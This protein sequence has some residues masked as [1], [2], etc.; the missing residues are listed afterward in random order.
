LDAAVVD[1]EMLFFSFDLVVGDGCERR[2]SSEAPRKVSE[3]GFFSLG[4]VRH[5]GLLWP[6]RYEM[7]ICYFEAFLGF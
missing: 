2:K 1:R 7:D 4:F 5:I 6:N 3:K